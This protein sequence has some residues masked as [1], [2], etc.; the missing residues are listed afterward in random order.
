MVQLLADR[1]GQPFSV[2][3]QRELKVIFN[4]KRAD[5]IQQIVDKHPEQRKQFIK[6][7]S[8][9][10][11]RAERAE[12]PVNIDCEMLRTEHKIPAPLRTIF[13]MFD[14]VGDPDKTDAWAYT[15]PS[16]L[17]FILKHGAKYTKDKPRWYYSNGYI[18]VYNENAMEYIGI[19]GIWPDQRDIKDFNC[20][21]VPCYTDD[22]PYEIPDDILNTMV[23]DILKNELRILVSPEQAEVT[24]KDG[25]AE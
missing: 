12:C 21:D 24:T 22:D 11:I 4:Y 9:T 3:L 10:L 2:P 14:Y 13:T 25:K 23:Q 15:T 19:A 7:I 5:Y 8:D 18:Y 16:Q 20:A 6:H 17:Y 1:V